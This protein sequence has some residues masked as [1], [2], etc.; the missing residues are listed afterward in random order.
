MNE[1]GKAQSAE[2]EKVLAGFAEVAR[3]LISGLSPAL[4][5]TALKQALKSPCAIRLGDST[6]GEI[7]LLR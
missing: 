4:V 1:F 3:G 7:Q 5:T 6:S 2:P